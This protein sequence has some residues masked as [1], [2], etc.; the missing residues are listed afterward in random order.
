[1]TTRILM[2]IL[3][4]LSLMSLAAKADLILPYEGSISEAGEAFRV[5]NTY[6][7]TTRSYGGYFEAAGAEGRGVYGRCTSTLADVNNY[8]G[9]FYAA[10]PKGRGVLGQSAGEQEGIGVKGYASN[11]GDILNFGGHFRADGLQGIGVYGLAHSVADTTNYG[12][13]FQAN[14]QRGIGVYALGGPHGYAGEFEGDVKIT[15]R[16]HGIVFPDGTRQTTAAAVVSTGGTGSVACA[17]KPAYDSGWVATPWGS[18]S[19]TLQKQ[20][21]HNLGGNAD[22]YVVDIQ[23]QQN[24]IAGPQPPT[25]RGLGTTFYY[26]GLTT[27]GITISGPGSAIDAGT[28][29]RVRIWLTNCDGGSGDDH[30]Y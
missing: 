1:M 21:T 10:G 8:G 17:A 7:G 6:T 15:G 12:G 3:L 25:N 26:S 5:N 20:L 24:T 23:K 30:G 9:F 28:Y 22:D 13:W 14:G 2:T 18:P 4:A 11:T 16:G 27:T 19:D 29:L